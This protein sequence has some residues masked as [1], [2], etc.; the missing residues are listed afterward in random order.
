LRRDGWKVIVI[1]E[2]QLKRPSRVVR[3]LAQLRMVC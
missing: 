1:W 3:A 2:C